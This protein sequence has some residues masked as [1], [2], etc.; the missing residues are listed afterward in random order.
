MFDIIMWQT[1]TV[2]SVCWVNHYLF[3]VLGRFYV[4]FIT[5]HTVLFTTSRDENYYHILMLCIT[6][7]WN[8][9]RFFNI[10]HVIHSWVTM[11]YHCVVVY[12]SSFWRMECL[13]CMLFHS[14]FSCAAILCFSLAWYSLFSDIHYFRYGISTLGRMH[15]HI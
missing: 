9:R 10:I 11:C 4:M 5:L 13:Y 1:K 3:C 14:L 2:V 8:F 7:A 15:R 6:G 12:Y